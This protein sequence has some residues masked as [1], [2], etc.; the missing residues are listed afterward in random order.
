MWGTIYYTDL[1]TKNGSKHNG[2]RVAKDT[3]VPLSNGDTL[4][5]GDT[6]LRIQMVAVLEGEDEE[7]MKVAESSSA[8]TVKASSVTSSSSAAAHP[9]KSSRNTRHNTAAVAANE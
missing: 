6:T 5:I 9:A 8:A 1:N 4:T 2:T 7:E 3:P